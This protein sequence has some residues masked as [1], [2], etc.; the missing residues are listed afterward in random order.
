MPKLPLV[1]CL[2]SALSKECVLLCRTE[3]SKDFIYAGQLPTS[4]GSE[5]LA[6]D[7]ED[8]IETARR[9]SQTTMPKVHDICTAKKLLTGKKKDDFKQGQLPWT[10]ENLI[11]P[12]LKDKHPLRMIRDFKNFALTEEE[13]I[14]RLTSY[15]SVILDAFSTCA[16]QIWKGLEEQNEL[17]RYL[18]IESPLYN[19]FI[20]TQLAGLT[21][22]RK[23]LEDVL[24]ELRS[25]YY[26]A[27]KILELEHGISSTRVSRNLVWEEFQEYDLDVPEEIR[28]IIKLE[29]Y[30]EFPVARGRILGLIETA[31]KSK[32]DYNS[33][34]KY[35]PDKFSKLYPK[36]DIIGTVSGRI[37]VLEPGIQY[38]KRR[39]RNIFAPDPGKEFIYAD[40]SQFEPGILVGLTN[41]DDLIQL[42]NEGDL[43]T[44]LSKRVLGK[45]DNRPLAKK[46]LISFIYG[47]NREKILATLEN[48]GCDRG[49]AESFLMM[50]QSTEKWR[51]DLIEKTEQSGGVSSIMGNTRYI[52]CK[53]N[54]SGREKLWIPNHRIQA[55]ASYLF[56]SALIQIIQNLP[57]F[58]LLLPMH[59]AILVEVEEKHA[60]E[61][62]IAI[63]EIMKKS[64]RKHFP[65]LLP[66]VHF[67]SFG[68]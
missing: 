35:S 33:L 18:A 62:R 25:T 10:L 40:Y 20:K 27:T 19:A 21:L 14:S 4:L 60:E 7:F 31:W 63:A 52:S 43:Y 54:I 65:R 48:H 49:A 56:K 46:T 41:D 38:L 39:L 2:H 15:L 67:E 32:N 36:F 45:K 58:R 55:T 1:I 26:K 3:D 9:L 8:Y 50:F 23:R 6:C 44:E 30:L 34:L 11:A 66:K 28:D 64:V 17:T 53:G 47:M 59:D 68:D 51:K 29:E 13:L 42:Y 5:L 16:D 37:M 12:Y 22:S 61:A 24:Y 57:T